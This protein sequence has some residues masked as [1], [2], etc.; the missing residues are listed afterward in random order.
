MRGDQP[1]AVDQRGEHE[2]HREAARHVDRESR[3][4]EQRLG[5]ALDQGIEPVPGDGADGASDR[6]RATGAGTRDSFRQQE[7]SAVGGG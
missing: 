4:G 2:A 6:N 3:P 5:A 7:P 1:P